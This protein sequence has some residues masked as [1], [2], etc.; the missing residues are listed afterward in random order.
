M[1]LALSP[2][3]IVYFLFVAPFHPRLVISMVSQMFIQNQKEEGVDLALML[4]FLIFFFFYLF[5]L[6][7]FVIRLPKSPIKNVAA[8]TFAEQSIAAL[9]IS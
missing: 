7:K 9:L 8:I 2:L 4:L 6:Q 5:L 3:L 1:P